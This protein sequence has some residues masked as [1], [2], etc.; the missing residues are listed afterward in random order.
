MANRA[1]DDIFGP[2]ERRLVALTDH[3]IAERRAGLLLGWE[4]NRLQN[5]HMTEA[6]RRL[7]DL[8]CTGR[9]SRHEY[10]VLVRGLAEVEAK[11]LA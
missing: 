1:L 4:L 9:I 2:Y 11:A 8:H 3:D 7:A 10:G 6:D 5:G